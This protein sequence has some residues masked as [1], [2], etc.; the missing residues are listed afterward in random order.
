VEGQ[1]WTTRS[2][3]GA[4]MPRPKLTIVTPSYNQ[5]PYIGATI[6]SVISQEGDFE[7][8]YFI[9][10]GGS[11]DDS[12]RVIAR[13]ADQLATGKWPIRC[14]GISLDWVSEP[15]LGQAHAI[16]GGLM[17]AKGDY[18]G[19]INSDDMYA[20]GA[21]ARVAE[22]FAHH[23]YADFLY[24]DGEVV[25]EGGKLQWPWLSRPFNLRLLTSYHFL[26]NDFTN[27]I[28][29]QSTFWRRDVMRRIGYLD[30]SF[31][32]GLDIEYWIRAAVH[33]LRLRHTPEVLGR[34]R[35]IPGTKSL[36]SPT[37]F[38]PD[39]L[40][41]LRRYRG[42][43]RLSSFFALYYFNLAR[44]YEFDLTKLTESK[45]EVFQRWRNLPRDEQQ[46][47]AQEAGRGFK[48]GCFLIAR[49]LLVR[50]DLQLANRFIAL[51]GP[52]SAAEGLHPLVWPYL[53]RRVLAPRASARVERFVQKAINAFRRWRYDYR[54]HQR[55]LRD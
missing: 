31:H 45:D 28:M 26:W 37:A 39:Y 15:D 40:E 32:Y 25:D 38:W 24:G 11:T 46:A 8:E 49:D 18:I 14:A 7:I 53:L 27:Y 29:Q 50:G 35:L 23:P 2:T 12:P 17:R 43:R 47:L 19:W 52:C 48:L 20:P 9:M 41:I 33:G 1:S 5:G 4:P 30:E 22:Q 21:F 44:Q 55:V 54:Y 3:S 42:P 34:F 36:S 13:Y 16:N 6:E 51:G 10:D